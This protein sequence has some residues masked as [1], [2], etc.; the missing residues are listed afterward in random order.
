[1]K[2]LMAIVAVAGA[3]TITVVVIRAS[4]GPTRSPAAFCQVYFQQ[5]QQYLSTYG[6]RSYSNDPLGG[7][8][9]VISAMSD[10]VPIFEKLDAV[11]PP[12]IEP[13]VSNIVD[14]LKQE[15]A[16]AGNAV[17]D[18]FGALGSGLMAGLMS[19]A[20]WDHVDQYIAQNCR[21]G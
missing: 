2:R 12:S 3:V 7:L 17:T 8:V 6:S 11:A 20:S 19:T 15:Q 5:K 9:T 14:S 10:W 16:A 13:D 21:G 4:S 1:M 18:P